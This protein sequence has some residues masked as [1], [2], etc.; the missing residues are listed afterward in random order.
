MILAKNCN[1]TKAMGSD[2]FLNGVIHFLCNY[3]TNTGQ[4]QLYLGS[5]CLREPMQ[6][7]TFVKYFCRWNNLNLSVLF[8]F[9][10]HSLIYCSVCL[11]FWRFPELLFPK[12][13]LDV[14]V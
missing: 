8:L 7:F 13:R 5:L 3:V 12:S 14:Y 10:F 11:T 9:I 1:I 2:Y 6:N 4:R